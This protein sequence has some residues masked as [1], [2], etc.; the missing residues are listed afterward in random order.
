MGRGEKQGRF[1]VLLHGYHCAMDARY[2]YKNYQ[3]KQSG[4]IH[5]QSEAADNKDEISCFCLFFPFLPQEMQGSTGPMIQVGKET[6]EREETT[7]GMVNREKT[8]HLMVSCR[9]DL[10]DIMPGLTFKGDGGGGGIWV[11]R[12]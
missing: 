5:L 4:N 12:V 6:W 2:R 10:F 8:A 11:G 1:K 7:L 9:W 3:K